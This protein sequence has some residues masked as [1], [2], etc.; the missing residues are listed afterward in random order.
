MCSRVGRGECLEMALS[1]KGR[2]QQK[3][4][5]AWL[6]PG[7]SWSAPALPRAEPAPRGPRPRGSAAGRRQERERPEAGAGGSRRSGKRRCVSVRPR[8]RST[9]RTGVTGGWNGRRWA[10]LKAGTRETCCHLLSQSGK[11]RRVPGVRVE[12]NG[13]RTTSWFEYQRFLM[14][15]VSQTA[16]FFLTFNLETPFC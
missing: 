6:V 2:G 4:R 9:E 10:F 5:D 15:T 8:S 12:F 1:A 3:L 7:L 14:G 13:E 16:F 11:S